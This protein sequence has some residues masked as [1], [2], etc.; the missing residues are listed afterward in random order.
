MIRKD[1]ITNEQIEKIIRVIN[2]GILAIV[3]VLGVTT[4]LDTGGFL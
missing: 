1:K 4:I 2:Y 3:I